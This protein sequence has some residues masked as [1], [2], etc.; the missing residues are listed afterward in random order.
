MGKHHAKF[1]VAIE[2]K[3][4]ERPVHKVVNKIDAHALAAALSPLVRQNLAALYSEVQMSIVKGFRSGIINDDKMRSAD[5]Y[6][7]PKYYR[8][9][10]DPLRDAPLEIGKFKG[11]DCGKIGE[12]EL[13]EI[14]KELVYSSHFKLILNHIFTN[15]LPKMKDNGS[16]IRKNDWEKTAEHFLR[17]DGQEEVRAHHQNSSAY[18]FDDF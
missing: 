18:S 2:K 14:V 9:L 3:V 15:V 7:R 17:P 1:P 16:W 10:I 8:Y 11:N 5:A 13:Q 12:N 6:S 4:T